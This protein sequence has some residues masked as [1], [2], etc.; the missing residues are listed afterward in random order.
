MLQPHHIFFLNNLL[1]Y[2]LPARRILGYIK[3]PLLTGKLSA[4]LWEFRT[5]FWGILQGYLIDHCLYRNLLYHTV[6][7]AIIFG[8]FC[9]VSHNSGPLRKH[10]FTCMCQ[11]DSLRF[12]IG[13]FV[14]FFKDRCFVIVLCRVKIDFLILVTCKNKA[15]SAFF[16]RQKIHPP[17]QDFL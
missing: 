4:N 2:S 12:M 1:V 15:T 13:G 8:F 9:C 14:S 16:L 3:R 11:K 17:Y 6:C 10:M 5:S 7:F